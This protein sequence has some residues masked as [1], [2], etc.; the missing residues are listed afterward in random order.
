M[1][2]D[3]LKGLLITHQKRLSLSQI[4]CH[5]YYK[6]YKQNKVSGIVIGKHL[7]PIDDNILNEITEHGFD[8]KVTKQCLQTNKHNSA[9]TTYYL[10]LKKKYEEG[11]HSFADMNSDRFNPM[12]LQVQY[13]HDNPKKRSISQ[14]SR[15][16]SSID[17]LLAKELK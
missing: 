6:L 9:T 17:D 4:R 12:L 13:I 8:K 16:K 14:H 15:H 10:M 5:D 7:I 1:A 2:K 3:I 11:F